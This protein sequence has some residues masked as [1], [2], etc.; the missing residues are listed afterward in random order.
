MLGQVQTIWAASVADTGSMVPGTWPAGTS[1]DGQACPAA[2][3]KACSV[4][5]LVASSPKALVVM[6]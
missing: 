2:A 4:L 5:F 3:C 1:M 6:G